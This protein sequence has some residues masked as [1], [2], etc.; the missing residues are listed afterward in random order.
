MRWKETIAGAA[1]GIGVLAACGQAPGDA[2]AGGG[3]EPSES[4]SEA[5]K[6]QPADHEAQDGPVPAD[7]LNGR[8]LPEG[9]PREAT[10]KGRTLTIT[11][12]E[13][14][15]G[16][17]SAEVTEQDAD[18]VSV[19][20]VETETAG[21]MMCTMD[22]RYPPVDVRLDAPLGERTLVLEHTTRKE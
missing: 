18:T 16:K 4:A 19:L 2:P 5:L 15:C 6:K 7:Q 20:L 1:L 9:F 8:G 3:H 12:Q 10:A 13:G 14:G 22:I 21:K 17:A 11:A